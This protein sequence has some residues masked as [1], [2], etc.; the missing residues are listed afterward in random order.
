MDRFAAIAKGVQPIRAISFLE[1]PLV[2][3][4]CEDNKG[5]IN[6]TRHRLYIV[7]C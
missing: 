5:E 7:L 2:G 6:E 4:S 3:G 1:P